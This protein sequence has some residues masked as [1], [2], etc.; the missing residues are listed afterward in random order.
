MPQ[1]KEIDG[2]TYKLCTKCKT[3]YPM[4]EEYFTKRENVKCG[5]DS[6]CKKCHQEKEK[7]RT[8]VSPFNENGKLKCL[9]CGEYKDVSEFNKGLK[10]KTRHDYSRECKTCE[11]IRKK[12]RRKR[13]NDSDIEHFF[14]HLIYGCRTRCRAIGKVCNLTPNDLI[15]LYEKQNHKCAISGLEMTTLRRAGKNIYNASIDR[16]S[17]GKDYTLENVRLVCNHVNM[18][19]SNLS[20]G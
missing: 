7:A 2:I 13:L 20:D 15:D 3:Y 17:P 19:R 16:I 11:S 4:T 1:F 18:M 12:E 10:N 6:H 9:V 5:F 14:R 8:R